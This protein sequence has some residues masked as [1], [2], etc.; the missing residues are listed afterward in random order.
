VKTVNEQTAPELPDDLREA[1][2]TAAGMVRDPRLLDALTESRMDIDLRR[3]AT[4]D[5]R[6]FLDSRGIELPRNLAIRFGQR[7]RP[8]MPG[9]DWEAFSIRL[10]DCRT[11]WIWVR[12]PITG[13]RKLS[14]EEI[15]WGVEIVPNPLP[16]GPVAGG[17]LRRARAS[18]H[19]K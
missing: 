9:P 8:W 3:Q 2:D 10:F 6:A 15:C 11:Y 18:A 7:P 1:Y 14:R 17:P 5:P 19:D 4:R 13:E 12:D 16:G